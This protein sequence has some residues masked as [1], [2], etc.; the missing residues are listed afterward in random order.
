MPKKELQ[1]QIEELKKKLKSYSELAKN[2][3]NQLIRS[4]LYK[5][6]DEKATIPFSKTDVSTVSNLRFGQRGFS[7]GSLKVPL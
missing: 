6:K 4:L 5:A 1:Q 3:S 2:A 7:Y